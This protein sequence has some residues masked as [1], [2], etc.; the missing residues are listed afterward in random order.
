MKAVRTLFAIAGLTFL[1]SAPAP[2]LDP[3][4]DISQYAHTAWTV[5]DGFSLGNIYAITQTPDGYLWLGTEFGLVRFDGIRAVP[6][7]PPAGQKLP[8]VNVNSLLLTRE[9][10]LWIGT[11]AGLAGLSGGKLIR[12]PEVGEQFVSSLFEDSKG[13]V[14]IGT[15]GDAGRLGRLYAMQGGRVQPYSQDVD[16][17]RAVWAMYEDS[18]GNLWAAAQSGLWRIKPSPPKQYPTRTE[19]IGFNRAQDGRLLVATHAGGLLQFVAD[20]LEPY[21]LRDASHLN[22]SMPDRDVDANR[23]V[24]DR[25]GGLWI[26]TVQRG[27]IHVYRGGTEVFTKADGLSGDIVLSVFEDREGDIWV[28][29]TGGLDRFRE[30]P[31]ITIAKK[32]GLSSD[33]TT[34]L[35]AT[36]DGSVWVAGRGLTRWNNGQTT[37]FN[38]ASGLPDDDVQSLFQDDDGRIWAST[39]HGLAYFTSGSFAAVNAL[40]SEKGHF[41]VSIT[42]DQ[43]D[44]L[45]LSGMDALFHVRDGRLI[46]QI[47]WPELRRRDLSAWV[48]LADREQGGLWLGFRDGDVSYFKDRQLRA[49]YTKADGLGAGPVVGLQLDRERALWVA[50][51]N[52]GLSRLKDGRISTLTTRNGLPCMGIHWS[53]EDNDG[54]FWLYTACGLVRIA[55]SELN[56]WIADPNR[57]IQTTVWDAADGV[58]IRSGPATGS[59]PWIAKSTDGKLWFVTGEGVQVV[60]PHRLALNK[61]PPLVHIEQIVADHKTYWENLPGAVSMRLPP[62]IRDLTIDYTAL[63]FVAPEKIH[64]KYKLEGQDTNWREVVNDRHVQYSNLRPGHYTFRVIASNNSGVWNENGDTLQFFV[65]PAYYQTNWFRALCA[66]AFL[67]LLWA[68]YQYRLRQLQHEFDITLDARVGERTRVARELH[69]TLLQKFQGVLPRFQAAIYK[70]PEDAVEARETLEAAVDQASEAITE[71]RDAVQGLR[72]ST[73]EK[74]DLGIAIRT[75]GEELAAS[76]GFS[77]KFEVVVEGKPHNLHPILR[78]EVY[79]I[80]AEAL[81]NAFKHARASQI[82]VEIGYGEKEFTLH[83][84]DDGSGIDRDVLAGRAGHFGLH[85][86]RERSELVGGD[87]TIWSE[88]ESGTEIELIIPASRAYTKS[89]RRF[90]FFERLSK[91][92][93]DAK[94]KIEL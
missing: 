23:V 1:W 12:V 33:A 82:E 61:V 74:N 26:G 86:M 25:D 52:G 62:R 24:R 54:A 84:G 66:L 77:A 60:D 4:L 10:T 29:T 16:F 90:W 94:E 63:S 27:L 8:N 79:R 38:K 30:L 64:F 71:G 50:T 89:V 31:V 70:L 46:D 51:N 39:V 81:R 48:V 3:S 83:V 17:G 85:G 59:G 34:C 57:R 69:D 21:P 18:S 53:I 2:A 65:T 32:Q 20:K 73:V 6:W 43:A 37:T 7:Q 44:N 5:K 11:F 56:A 92:G 68:V 76:N 40:H 42:G 19:L 93:A 47:S 87:L 75:I 45:W 91:R 9:G 72:M 88:L 14:W 67:V 13:T 49:T 36:V 80:A 55:R 58:R 15:M 28:A 78:D 22:R 35:L 41:I